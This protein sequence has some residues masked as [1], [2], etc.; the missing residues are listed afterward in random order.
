MNQTLGVLVLV[1]FI[2]S[3]PK[4]RK[5]VEVHYVCFLAHTIGY[6]F[7]PLDCTSRIF[8][9]SK[10]VQEVLRPS[11]ESCYYHYHFCCWLGCY[12]SCAFMLNSSPYSLKHRDATFIPFI[13]QQRLRKNN[14]DYEILIQ[15]LPYPQTKSIYFAISQMSGWTHAI[16]SATRAYGCVDRCFK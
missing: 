16:I 15:F 14:F 10:N 1:S 11:G 7:L 8:K 3:I 6:L 5:I 4:F 12:L 9:E 13:V 2:G